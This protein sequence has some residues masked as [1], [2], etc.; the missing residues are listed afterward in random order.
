MKAKYI[1]IALLALLMAYTVYRMISYENELRQQRIVKT[2]L[3]D[4]TKPL[5]EKLSLDELQS[6]SD[7]S[8]YYFS[9]TGDYF[10]H[11]MYDY[12]LDLYKWDT[13]LYKGVNMGVALPGNFPGDFPMTFDHYLS[14]LKQ[15]G[16][17]HANIV[18]VY[19]ILP[20]DFYDAFAYYNLHHQDNPLF[21][22][23]GVWA[24]M[25]DDENHFNASYSRTLKKEI[26]DVVNVIHGN[27]VI[28]KTQGKAHG[29]YS[30][31]ISK[32]VAS[33]LF[34][35][36]WEPSTVHITNSKSTT[37]QYAGEFISVNNGT[38]MEVWL[39]E[40][41]NFIVLYETQTYLAQRPVSFVNWLPLDPMYHNAEFIESDN[42]KE[43]D[44]DL[45]IVDYNNFHSSGLFRP[46][47]YAS[48]HTYP[49][50]PDFVYQDEKYLHP[51]SDSTVDTYRAYL[52]HLKSFHPGMPLLISE[53]GVPSSRGNSHITPCGFDQGGHDELDHAVKNLKLTKD[54]FETGS[55]GAIF[56]EWADEWFKH[57]WLVMDFEQ[58]ADERKNWHNL[59]NPEQNFGIL[60]LESRTKT[61]DGK[62]D[63]W[64]KVK[65]KRNHK[66]KYAFDV[67]PGY[68][69][70][71]IKFDA[72]NFNENNLYIAFDVINNK[73]GDHQLPFTD[74]TFNNGFEFL[75]EIH[76]LSEARLLVD[77]PFNIFSDVAKG[78]VPSYASK[79]N[80]NGIFTEQKLL[81]NRQRESLTGTIFGE[82]LFNR[83]HMVHGNSSYARYSNADWYFNE[84]TGV[85]EI[86]LTWQMLNVTS[87]GRRAILD[88]DPNKKGIQFSET[89]GFNIFLFKTDKENTILQQVPKRKPS[90]FVWERWGESPEYK[91][92]LKPIY[93]S[94][95][96]YF[97]TLHLK[98]LPTVTYTS[99]IQK[100]ELC[101]YYNGK[102][103]ALSISFED[104]YLS[105]YESAFPVLEKYNLPATFGI[106][107]EYISSYGHS[108]STDAT[109]RYNKISKKELEVLVK[110]GYA[111]A[112]QMMKSETPIIEQAANL[113]AITGNDV[114]TAFQ[115][116]ATTANTNEKPFLFTRPFGVSNTTKINDNLIDYTLIPAARVSSDELL[117][118]VTNKNNWFIVA[119]SNVLQGYDINRSK[120]I[121]HNTFIID[122]KEFEKQIRLLRNTEYWIAPEADV[123]KYRMQKQT[124]KLNT[125]IH[126]QYIFIMISH[127]LNKMVYNHPMTVKIP[128]EAPYLQ[129]SGTLFDG[130]YTNRTGE[131]LIHAIPG[132]E[133][134]I[135]QIW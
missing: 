110:N 75:L 133:V 62:L 44:N 71:A 17:M 21:L 5:I 67:D 85:V 99:K 53:Y 24:S 134:I 111:F 47:I 54:I 109:G 38:P 52:K 72:L 63:D 92:R 8:S 61:I 28:S 2:Y 69:Y 31:D 20:P 12:Q 30:T 106:V 112:L 68:F 117:N 125:T 29:V 78:I 70:I 43:Y 16:A 26:A 93:D 73:K 42:I 10:K 108:Y 82:A 132:Q 95:K 87:P 124:A 56:F 51:G 121:Q 11:L 102:D 100:P 49:Y 101:S 3:E 88:N 14:W 115:N 126:N 91:E 76:N 107:D 103:A 57:N 79:K 4:E 114:F 98:D 32:W 77:E 65:F 18:R 64:S 41:L 90:H 84:E 19:T 96:N 46:G 74:K 122:E 80:A 35:R 83:S 22:I 33:I 6:L 94:L 118:I 119:Y 58:P 135:K 15:I 36:E 66:V 55:A 116:K 89:D 1:I 113:K 59:E 97:R 9:C 123:Y 81:T 23:Q 86:R 131:I 129:V 7:K 39:A 105:Q 128:V 45:E 120:E 40:M 25:P 104:S 48:Y 13:L 50:Y 127:Q 27:A 37:N 60:A 130:I 34:G